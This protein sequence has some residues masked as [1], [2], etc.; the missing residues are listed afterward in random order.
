[1]N[2]YP[3]KGNSTRYLRTKSAIKEGRFNVEVGGF[4]FVQDA[5][6]KTKFHMPGGQVVSLPWIYKQAADKGWGEIRKRYIQRQTA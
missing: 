3:S 4:V 6:D 2:G 5:K 1:M